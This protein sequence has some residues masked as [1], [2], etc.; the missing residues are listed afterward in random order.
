MPA[1]TDT[2]LRESLEALKRLQAREA[3][4]LRHNNALL[5]GLESMTRAT[6]P[7]EA[8]EALLALVARTFNAGLVGLVRQLPEPGHFRLQRAT[9]PR[10]QDL[11]FEAPPGLIARAHH[12]AAPADILAPAAADGLPMGSLML[13]P[14]PVPEG[15]PVALAC[16]AHATAAFAA[17][18]LQFLGRLARLT[19]HAMTTAMLDER[20]A[21]LAAVIEGSS[22][23]LSI[24][25][26]RDP[27]LPVIYVNEA[28]C[29][30]TGY[31]PL[32]VLGRN[33]RFMAGEPGD[34][35]ERSRLREAVE[36][37]KGGRFEVVNRRRDGSSFLNQLT[38]FPVGGSPEA[39]R[40]LVGTQFDIT[41][42]RALEHERNAAHERLVAALGSAKQGFVVIDPAGKVVL[43]NR[44][45][46]DF[47]PAGADGWPEGARFVDCWRRHLVESGTPPE[48]AAVAA[49][50]R[51]AELLAGKPAA[52]VRS[53]TGRIALLNDRPTPDGGAVA[54][55]TD[56][57]ERVATE[58]RLAEQ[59][60]AMDASNDGIAFTDAEGRFIYMNPAHARMFGFPEDAPPLGQPWSILYTEE[61]V[62][63]LKRT[64][65]PV[66]GSVG[67]WRGEAVGRRADG[68]PV[69]QEVSLSLREDG[70]IVCA[71]R[72]IGERR[73]AEREKVRLREQLQVAQRQEAIGQLASGLAHDLNNLLAAISGSATLIE[74]QGTAEC[75]VHAGRIQAAAGMAT[76]LVHKMLS[77]GSRRPER[78]RVDLAR[79][80]RESADLL[81][82]GLPAQHRLD[83]QLPDG[84]I[85]A[86]A[87]PTEVIQVLLN[88]GINARDALP[89]RDGVIRMHLAPASESDRG[90]ELV[91]GT[92][93]QGP[94]AVLSVADNGCGIA[95]ADIARIFQPYYSSKGEAGT[96]LGLA[97]VA[98]I[99]NAAG[100]GIAVSRTPGGGAT[101]RI[102]W[103]L[104][105]APQPQPMRLSAPRGELAGLG[106]LLVD[107]NP[108]VVETLA[109]FLEDAGAEPGPSLDPADTLLALREDPDAWALLVTDFDMPG[110]NGAELA[111]AAR[112]IRPDLPILLCTA[113][114]E[115]H[116]QPSDALFDI[117]IGK[118][119]N[120]DN[121]L[122][123]AEAAIARHARRTTP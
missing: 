12:V 58:A 37:L 104:E 56:V 54:T 16:F 55:L 65:F 112:K 59:A 3:V 116:R 115:A 1:V 61:A 85:E 84:A 114:P 74:D 78:R 40:Y 60:A 121:F 117:V 100:A 89:P 79:L 91:F 62:E 51:L 17:E 110:M 93:P 94:A 4:A 111:Q 63:E 96:G 80:V 76:S 30:L 44:G 86:E 90:T 49:A 39:P 27:N 10:F 20:N 2:K 28:F 99:V 92:M 42:T 6:S 14:L 67:Q 97:V 70:G 7:A 69:E 8:I 15:P 118:P 64:A 95:D 120:P 19:A 52:E 98:G 25:D 26:A 38:L 45:W 68:S 103:P 75:R 46:S 21:L 5:D 119:V 123:A 109:R 108:V 9:D 72:D 31:A 43:A 36:T 71:T 35:P 48:E 23:A 102:F 33:C 77:F 24:A 81:R 13:A 50:A 73:A 32:E 101:F 82:A 83:I 105:P 29:R 122:A 87:D 11:A 18:D 107:D 57:T 41:E 47:F 22:T 88:L 106:V 66:L 34:S 113:L 53:V